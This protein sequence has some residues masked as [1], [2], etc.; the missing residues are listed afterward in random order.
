MRKLLLFILMGNISFI[1]GQ[2]SEDTTQNQSTILVKIDSLN[3]IKDS[4]NFQ[5]KEVEGITL[6]YEI[7]T[8]QVHD[9]I[10]Y[11]INK[12]SIYKGSGGWGY[13]EKDYVMDVPKGTK[14]IVT[15]EV[16]SL[17]AYEIILNGKK[18]FVKSNCILSE[19]DYTYYI[20]E[21]EKLRLTD[22]INLQLKEIEIMLAELGDGN[23]YFFS[24]NCSIY[25]GSGWG[26]QEKDFI[27]VVPKGTKVIVTKE[28]LALYAYEIILNGKRYFAKSNCLLSEKDY[29]FHLK[30][31]ENLK[32][33]KEEL[34]IKDSVAYANPTLHFFK[35]DGW[36]YDST[37]KYI[38]RCKGNLIQVKKGTIV[39]FVKEI[40]MDRCLVFYN[41]KLH[42]TSLEYLISEATILERKK[43]RSNEKARLEK[44]KRE[45]LDY[46]LTRLKNLK[47]KYGETKGQDIFD[48]MIWIGMS[49]EMATD[50]KGKPNKINRTGT[51]FGIKEQWVYSS[52][53]YLYFQN[54][55][56]EAWQD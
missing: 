13:K 43:Q 34:R 25:K 44:R 15:K 51:Q 48:G 11:F 3:R 17:Y 38:R 6:K 32:K 31:E 4:L 47:I 9:N 50:S 30:E 42:C 1:I 35:K 53:V 49:K 18:Y 14:V 55:Y 26:Y 8:D 33:E 20:K 2:V 5:L 45:E 10:Y 39:Y 52:G 37:D 28:V 56:L 7:L 21:K 29:A 12:C 41:E 40:S 23:V 27:K 54:N 22:T 24:N 36:L 19:K 46:Q 16:S